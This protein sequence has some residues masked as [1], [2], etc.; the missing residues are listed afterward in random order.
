MTGRRQAAGGPDERAAPANTVLLRGRLTAEPVEREL[1]SGD[2]IV[3]FRVSVPR[4]G[5]TPLTARSRQTSDWVDCAAAAPGVRRRVLA[6]KPGDAVEVEGAL[7]R[8]FYRAAGAPVSRLEVEV[9]RAR[10]AA[11]AEPTRRAG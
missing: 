10:R 3:T 6:W 11:V 5:G 7:R 8:R 2:V 9:A 4:S 1:P